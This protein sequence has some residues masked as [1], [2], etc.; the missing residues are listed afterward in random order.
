MAILLGTVG[1]VMLYMNGYWNNLMWFSAIIAVGI[2]FLIQ[3]YLKT[4]KMQKR[5]RQKIKEI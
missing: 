4:P 1:H 5:Q 3:K 2:P